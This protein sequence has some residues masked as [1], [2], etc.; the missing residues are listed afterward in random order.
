MKE[1]QSNLTIS[2]L[3]QTLLCERNIVCLHC[4]TEFEEDDYAYAWETG[5]CQYCHKPLHNGKE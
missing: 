5:L 4:G 1:Q 3:K 2:Q